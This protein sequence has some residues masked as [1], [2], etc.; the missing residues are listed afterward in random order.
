MIAPVFQLVSLIGQLVKKESCNAGDLGSIP[1]LGRSP[2]E[3]K[4]YPLQYSGLENSMGSQRVRHNWVTFTF[5]PP[6]S[7]KGMLWKST[8][9]HATSE[10]RLCLGSHLQSRG[11]SLQQLTNSYAI[12]SITIPFSS[13]CSYFF[14]HLVLPASLHT[15]QASI[16]GPVPWLGLP[17]GILSLIYLQVPITPFSAGIPSPARSLQTILF[18]FALPSPILPA[19]LALGLQ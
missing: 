5:C 8:S 12:L 2:E 13:H 3:G 6:H 16:T 11:Q 14:T 9:H 15:R 10:L 19:S 7:N 18:T 17:P 4:G 1:G